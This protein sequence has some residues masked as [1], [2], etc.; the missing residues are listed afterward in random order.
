VSR[1]SYDEDHSISNFYNM[2][3]SFERQK[4][5]LLGLLW[6][7]IVTQIVVL[8]NPKSASGFRPLVAAI[9]SRFFDFL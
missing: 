9:R 4:K 6:P 8:S 7:L 3:V 2:N 1:D 5:K